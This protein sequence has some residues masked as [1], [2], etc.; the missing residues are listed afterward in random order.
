MNFEIRQL[1]SWTELNE[2]LSVL[3]NIW[4]LSDLDKESRVTLK[5]LTMQ[6]PKTGILLGCFDGSKMIGIA[7]GF[8]CIETDSIY[9]HMLGIID[10]YRNTGACDQLIIEFFKICLLL[11]KNRLFWTFEPLSSKLAHIYL[12]K[13]GAQGIKYYEN[14]YQASDE[15]NKDVPLDRFLAQ[16]ELTEEKLQIIQQKKHE[17]KDFKEALLNIPIASIGNFPDSNEVLVEIPKD[18]H[19]IKNQDINNALLWRS[20]TSIIFNEYVNKRGYQAVYLITG[21]VNEK[22]CSFYCLKKNNS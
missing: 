11:K 15:L 7:S 21:E 12:N 5:A 18:F 6:H 3:E 14:Y 13:Q 2:Y 22:H 19:L 1:N 4:G 16:L 10:D 8:A 17:K 20:Q 9:C